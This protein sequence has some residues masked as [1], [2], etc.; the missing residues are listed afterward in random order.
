MFNISSAADPIFTMMLSSVLLSEPFGG[1]EIG[2]AICSFV[3]VVLVSNPHL[4]IDFSAG[5]PPGFAIGCFAILASSIVN[6]MTCC[7]VRAASSQVH[8]MV[9]VLAMGIGVAVFGAMLGGISPSMMTADPVALR[10]VVIG[11][12]GGL[13]GTTCLH[14]AF[15]FCRAGTGTLMRN[16]DVPVSY[17]LGVAVLGEIPH[18]VSL[19]GSVL[20]VG[21]TCVVG[22]R[23][24]LGKKESDLKQRIVEAPRGK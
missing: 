17:M 8:F 2:A 11:S 12:L 6:A 14:K 23:S 5:Q 22:L 24:L 20:V 4:Q 13:F 10:I 18:V 19:F 21:G 3:G 7:M 16:V 9:F 1:I 15:R